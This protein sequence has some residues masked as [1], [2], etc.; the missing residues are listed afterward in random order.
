MGE[1]SSPINYLD[2]KNLFNSAN[3][4]STFM[5]CT[6]LAISK[7]SIVAP[8]QPRHLRPKFKK[9]AAEPWSILKISATVISFVIIAILL[10]LLK[11][12]L[13]L[14]NGITFILHNQ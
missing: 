2:S 7:F 6:L 3:K 11:K 10:P 9:I 1:Q 12:Y 4:S 5:P 14:Y 13:N 8:G